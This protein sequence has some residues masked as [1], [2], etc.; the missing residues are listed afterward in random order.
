[1]KTI[2]AAWKMKR[3]M[4]AIV[5]LCVVVGCGSKPSTP[6]PSQEAQAPIQ[7]PMLDPISRCGLEDPPC[8][9]QPQ[10]GIRKV[11]GKDGIYLVENSRIDPIVPPSFKLS[12]YVLEETGANVNVSAVGALT[13]DG[14][15]VTGTASVVST[16][17][18]RVDLLSVVEW[19]ELQ[20]TPLKDVEAERVKIAKAHGVNVYTA[21]DCRPN[22][23]CAAD[24][25]YLPPADAYEFRGQFLLVNVPEGE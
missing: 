17:S 19:E 25:I 21:P 1:M 20:N 12:P 15:V 22:I 8:S 18:G 7:Q 23:A 2:V 14:K 9:H 6:K 4:F 10:Y 16:S 3:S 5:M 13:V 24:A 11:N